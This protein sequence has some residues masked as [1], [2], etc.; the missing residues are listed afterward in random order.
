M[1]SSRLISPN[2]TKDNQKKNNKQ[3]SRNPNY[4]KD[5]KNSKESSNYLAVD[6]QKYKNGGSKSARKV[7]SDVR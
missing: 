4:E 7:S 5:S 2:Q 6:S 1:I 3:D